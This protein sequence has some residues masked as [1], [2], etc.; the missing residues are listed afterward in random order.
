MD[1]TTPKYV[2]VEEHIKRAIKNKT[3]KDRLPGE[4]QLAKELGFS[5]M[6]IRKAIDNLVNDGVLYKVPTKGTFVADQNTGKKAETLTIGYFLDSSIEAGISSPYYSLVF[7]ALEKEAGRHGYSLTYFSDG[8]EQKLSKTLKKLDGV[9]ATCFPRI[10]NVIADIKEKVPV[11]VMDNSTA[12]KSIPSV[13]IDNYT[14]E[15]EAVDYV[16]SLGHKRIG[17]MCGLNDSEIGANR[18]SGFQRGLKNNGIDYDESLIYFGNYSYE[19]GLSGGDYFLSLDQLPSAI[20]C[21]NDTMAMGVMSRL[22][23][24]GINVP[25]DVSIVGFDDIMVASRISPALTT[26]AAP[27]A[28]LAERAFHMLK[29]L[30]KG[31][32]VETRHLAL[33][34]RLMIRETTATVKKSSEVAAA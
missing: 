7:Q 23:K 11:V 29:D 12:D 20:I 5:Y 18:L 32:E 8:G 16:C 3:I 34:A 14:A 22:H 28:E 13:I 6:T 27:V 15:T 10:E 19:A 33:P 31:K 17:F 2:L 24:Q 9:I 30:I 26:L 25:D 4:R 21:S 1:V